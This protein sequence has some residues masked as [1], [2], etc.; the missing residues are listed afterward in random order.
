[1][2]RFNDFSLFFQINSNF[3]ILSFNLSFMDMFDRFLIIFAY[4]TVFA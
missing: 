4:I 3:S 2:Q 1:M